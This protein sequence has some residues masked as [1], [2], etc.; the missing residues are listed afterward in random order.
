MLSVYDTR[1]E[2]R[3]SEA[4]IL[5]GNGNLVESGP[6]GD[7]ERHYA[8][9]HDPHPKPTYLFAVVGGALAK[10]AKPFVTASG[11]AVELAIYVEPGKQGR[12]GYAL[13]AL[14]RLDALGRGRPSAGSTISTCSTSSPCRIS[15]WGRWRTRG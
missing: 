9:W 3:V 7:G 14:E 2:A 8:L 13:D 4:P 11:R 15:T 1:I 10:I 6:V 5:L 12:A